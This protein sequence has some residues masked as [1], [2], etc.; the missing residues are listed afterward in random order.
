M[1]HIDRPIIPP[2]IGRAQLEAQLKTRADFTANQA[3][4]ALDTMVQLIIEHLEVGTD[5]SIPRLGIFSCTHSE[6][7]GRRVTFRPDRTLNRNL[8]MYAEVVAE[9]THQRHDDAR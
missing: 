7:L 8:R 5:V 6:K 2:R 9:S 4:V 1:A 3:E